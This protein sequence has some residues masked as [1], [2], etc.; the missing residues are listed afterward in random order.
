[1]EVARSVLSGRE[2]S[3]DLAYSGCVERVR[4]F[5]SRMVDDAE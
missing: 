2:K 1:M 4:S 5:G 3:R